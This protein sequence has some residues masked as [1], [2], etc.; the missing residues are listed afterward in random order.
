MT[1]GHQI[2]KPRSD[3]KKSV[4]DW[5]L[6]DT[7]VREIVL[8]SFPRYATNGRHRKGAARW[9]RVIHLY[10]RMGMT[11]GQVAEEMSLGTG[12]IRNILLHIRRV[13]AGM[14]ANGKKRLGL[15]PRGRPKKIVSLSEP[16]VAAHEKPNLFRSRTLLSYRTHR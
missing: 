16:I 7:K 12:V 5:A 2:V 8:R 3:D 14:Q 15:R 13:V 6:D 1:K 11:R 10:F 4:P 9:I